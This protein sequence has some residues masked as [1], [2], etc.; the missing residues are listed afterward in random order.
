MST[1]RVLL[2]WAAVVIATVALVLAVHGIGEDGL[3]AAIRATARLSAVAIACAFAEFR[4][5][6]ALMALPISHAAHYA[7]IGV[8]AWVTNPANAGMDVIT[9]PG[10]ALLF[11]LMIYAAAKQPRWAIYTLW[12]IFVLTFAIRMHE[13]WIYPLIVGLLLATAVFRFR[14]A[15]QRADT[16][17]Q[18]LRTD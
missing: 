6:E 7:L 11:V 5:R 18:S 14:G 13:S 2:I 15:V 1:R 9:T 3:R 10:G 8:L 4:K 17:A 16:G 12:I